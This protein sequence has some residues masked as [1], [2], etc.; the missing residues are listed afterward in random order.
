MIGP[1]SPFTR[2]DAAIR[3]YNIFCCA[4]WYGRYYFLIEKIGT[5]VIELNK[6]II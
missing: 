3:W 1:Y 2:I 6:E 4:E 5:F